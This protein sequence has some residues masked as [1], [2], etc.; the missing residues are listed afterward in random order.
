M[1]LA[2]RGHAACLST[3]DPFVLR[4]HEPNL[5]SD[6]KLIEVAI[7]HTVLVK[8]DFL[9]I[10]DFVGTDVRGI[11]GLAWDDREYHVRPCFLKAPAAAR[12]QADG[13]S[14]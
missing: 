3:L 1:V 13:L 7:D 10:R 14:G 4:D 11:S 8:I 5:V 9:A 6:L 12:Q 2:D